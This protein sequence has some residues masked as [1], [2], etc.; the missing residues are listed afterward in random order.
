MNPFSFTGYT[1]STSNGSIFIQWRVSGFGADK[2]FAFSNLDPV[3]T[4]LASDGFFAT[5]TSVTNGL[6]SILT[7]EVTNQHNGTEIICED[8]GVLIISSYN[9]TLRGIVSDV[10]IT[11]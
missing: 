10:I 5:L 8:P 2:A 3:G 6:Q 7:F 1:C 4:T 11:H 9:I